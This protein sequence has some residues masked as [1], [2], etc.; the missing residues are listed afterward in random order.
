MAILNIFKKKKPVAASA[1]ASK[2]EKSVKEEKTQEKK[3]VKIESLKTK[4]ENIRS[5]KVRFGRSYKVLKSPHV[6]EKVGDLAEKNQYIFRVFP[7]TNKTEV[8]RAIEETY[9]VMVV[10]VKII[11]VPEKKRRLGKIQGRRPGY[12]KAIVKIEKGQKIEALSR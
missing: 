11:N 12:K 2:K 10:S 4:S 9:G 1:Q 8:K 5:P 6:S 3:E 7:E